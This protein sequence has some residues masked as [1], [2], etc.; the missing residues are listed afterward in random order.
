MKTQL[1]VW[2]LLVVLTVT[3]SLGALAGPLAP[4]FEK[5][6]AIGNQFEIS[7]SELALQS[8]HNDAVRQFAQQ[9]IDD[10]KQIGDQMSA[11]LTASPTPLPPP[12]TVLDHQHQKM[13]DDLKTVSGP[14]FDKKYIGEQIKAHK[15]AVKLFKDYN[16]NGDNDSLKGFAAS[17]LPVIE[18]HLDHIK[19]IKSAY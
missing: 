18:G 16:K 13:L 8:S 5:K 14:D 2:V 11:A 9:M 19:Q 10:H 15:E 6:A 17:A 12:P 4:D 3:A 1:T 7:S